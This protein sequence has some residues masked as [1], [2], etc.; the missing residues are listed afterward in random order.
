MAA[1][2]VSGAWNLTAIKH[3]NSAERVNAE[4]TAR[5]LPAQSM[6]HSAPP[7]SSAAW[8]SEP[9]QWGWA[10]DAAHCRDVAGSAVLGVNAGMADLQ[11]WG[12]SAVCSL[13]CLGVKVEWCWKCSSVGHC[14]GLAARVRASR[15]MLRGK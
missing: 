7:S 9:W 8:S 6:W 1:G 2:L 3:N 12:G 4:N 14:C 11:P 15:V 5:G 10:A 13:Q